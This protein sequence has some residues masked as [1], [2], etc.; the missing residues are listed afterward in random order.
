MCIIGV[1]FWDWCSYPAGTGQGGLGWS[2][3]WSFLLLTIYPLEGFSIQMLVDLMAQSLFYASLSLFSYSSQSTRVWRWKHISCLKRPI[4]EMKVLRMVKVKSTLL[5][6]HV[7][8][9]VRFRRL[10]DVPPLR[11][12]ETV[13]REHATRTYARQTFHSRV[14]L[15]LSRDLACRCSRAYFWV[16]CRKA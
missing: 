11:V 10:C 12:D 6:Q 5:S 13:E 16:R 4:G 14:A 7:G 3:S 1:A 15:D 9:V 8:S 2:R